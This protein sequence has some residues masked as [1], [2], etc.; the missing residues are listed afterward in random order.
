MLVYIGSPVA[1]EILRT[2]CFAGAQNDI[3]F[4]FFIC[5][6]YIIYIV[7][8]YRRATD[9]RP[10]GVAVLTAKTITRTNGKS[11]TV[12]ACM[13]RQ[14]GSFDI[15]HRKDQTEKCKKICHSERSEESPV[16]VLS[17]QSRWCGDSSLPPLAGSE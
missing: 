2:P 5:Y 1:A 3:F 10:Y 15:H 8:A 4:L 12:G 13:A 7:I 11:C 16:L 9:G 14:W 17:W 6:R